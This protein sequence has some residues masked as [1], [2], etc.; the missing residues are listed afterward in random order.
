MG[1]GPSL[2]SCDL[3]RLARETTIVSNANYLMWDQ[4]D[5]VPTFLTVEDS[6]TAEDRAS[7]LQSLQGCVR[8]FP[9]DLRRFLGDSGETLL[10]LNLLRNYAPFPK[11]SW[12]VAHHAY[13]GGTVSFLNL[14]IAAFLGCNPI[15]L[16]GF[17]HSYVV[18]ASETDNVV[19][20]S[21]DADVNHFS[22]DYL[23]PGQRWYAPNVPRMEAAYRHAHGE[24]EQAGY[25][26]LN[27][28]PGGKLEVFERVSLDSIL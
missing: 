16:I 5:Y 11:F 12:N 26:V 9:F 7:D 28:T 22:P 15:I 24:L 14:L 19:I 17:D 18:P 23:G 2:L 25:K 10:Y 3:N 8:I 6:L 21:H 13:W 20:R 27:A 4:L 1:N